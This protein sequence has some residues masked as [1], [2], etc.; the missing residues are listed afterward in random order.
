MFPH[1]SHWFALLK[2][3][4]RTFLFVVLFCAGVM[5]WIVTFFDGNAD[6][7]IECAVVFGAAVHGEG[8]AGPGIARRTSTAVRL[9]NE[10]KV[11]TLIMTGGQGS[12]GQESEAAVMKKVA[13]RGGVDPD[14]IRLE[15]TATSTWENLKMSKPLTEDC[16]SVIGVSDRYHIAR[17]AYVAWLQGWTGFHVHPADVVADR[18]FELRS[19]FREMLGVVYYSSLYFMG[20][21]PG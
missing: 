17:I 3:L 12:S 5:V 2:V 11:Q 15:E 7:P 19:V 20:S 4:F 1:R 8:S 18:S 21:L 10:Q 6:F 14:D 16:T 13:M 9:Y